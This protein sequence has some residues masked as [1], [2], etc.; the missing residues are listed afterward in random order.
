M[1]QQ[2]V[3]ERLQEAGIDS[4]RFEAMQLCR[5]LSGEALVC[6]VERRCAGY[7]LQYILGEWDF[8]R[9]TYEVSEDC[10][11]P[12][13][14]T[15]LLVEKAVQNLPTGARFL[16]LCTG[17]GCVAI[18][19]LCARPDTTAVAV[20]LFAATL[21][22]AGRNRGRNGV[23]QRL[24]LVQADVLLPPD[25]RFERASWDAILSNP[26]YIR[27]QVVP[28][29]QREV[30]YEPRAALDGGHDGLA[31]YRAILDG[32]HT[33]LKPGG[34]FFFEIGYDQGEALVA[35]AAERGY[36]ATVYR[37]LGGNDRV[38]HIRK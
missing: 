35:L 20:D 10:L 12:R 7:P 33:L 36:T 22:L 38:V 28:T 5:A 13:A 32:W 4:P 8:Y 15:E 6:A 27:T 18:S 23:T 17:S 16:D 14:D 2:A 31:F 30:G 9:E 37:D 24:E 29:L 21:E 26:P 3:M 1:N 34:S 19:T 11:I 25:G